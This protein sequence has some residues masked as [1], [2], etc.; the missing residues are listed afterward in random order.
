MTDKTQKELTEQIEEVLYDLPLDFINTAGYWD[1]EEKEKVMAK[2]LSQLL[3]IVNQA[4]NKKVKELE[5]K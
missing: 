4:V 5:G 2:A 1:H 3:D